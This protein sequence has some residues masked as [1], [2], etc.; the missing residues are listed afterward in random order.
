MRR[1]YI[2]TSSSCNNKQDLYN[3]HGKEEINNF[4]EKK[5]TETTTSSSS[6]SS[7]RLG[8]KREIIV[9]KKLERMETED[10]DAK[11]DEFIK[12]FKQHL[13]I[14]RLQSIENYEQMLQ[15]GL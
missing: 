7:H 6:S 9:T 13:L 8:K 3:K 2:Q 10:I 15:R 4:K 1:S 12:N 14:Q 11:A 5:N